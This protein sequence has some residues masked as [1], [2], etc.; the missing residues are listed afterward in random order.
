L[1]YAGA[2]LV[3]F[4]ANQLSNPLKIEQWDIDPLKIDQ[5]DIRII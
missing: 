5:W 2:F 1:Y 4:V 3:G